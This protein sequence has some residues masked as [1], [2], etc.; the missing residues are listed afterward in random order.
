MIEPFAPG[1]HVSNDRVEKIDIF[2]C[3]VHIAQSDPGVS[4]CD[5]VNLNFDGFVE[6]FCKYKQ[7]I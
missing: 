5:I 7:I 1:Y 6:V 3:N 4:E 2:E